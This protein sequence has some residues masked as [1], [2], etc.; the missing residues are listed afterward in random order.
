MAQLANYQT[1]PTLQEAAGL[2]DL[3]EAHQIRYEIDDS[4]MRFGLSANDN[5]LETGVIIKINADDVEKVK[6]IDVHNVPA[7]FTANHYLHTFSDNDIMD[8]FVNPEEWTDE[9]IALA[10][11][12]AA[13]RNLQLTAE[14]VKYSREK[15]YTETVKELRAQI[16]EEFAIR[17]RA[18]WF[19][20]IGGATFANLFVTATNLYLPIGLRANW[21]FLNALGNAGIWGNGLY[22]LVFVFGALLPLLFVWIWWQ[23]RKGNRAVYLAG[24]ILYAVDTVLCVMAQDWLITA[25]HLV[26]LIALCDGYIRLLASKKKKKLENEGV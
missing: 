16:A 1:F 21:H 11:E 9:E 20:W 14:A 17:G 24:M 5:L 23:S 15:S 3:L 26:G 18:S 19:V 12:I 2:I 4:S 25:F 10:R 22:W 8:I 7:E 6:A 13:Q